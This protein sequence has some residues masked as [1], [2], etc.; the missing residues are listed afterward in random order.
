MKKLIKK[1]IIFFTI[2]ILIIIGSLVVL[3]TKYPIGYKSAIVKYSNEYNLDPYL[4]ASII[5]VESK[6][7][8]NAVSSKEAKGLM[9]IAPQTGQWAS[10]VLGI[11]NYN[12]KML[13]DPEIN[14]RIGTWYLNNLFTEFNQNLDLVLA[15]YNAGSGNVNKWLDNDEYCKDGV[16]LSVIPFKETRDYLVRI[17]DNYKVYSSVYKEYIMNPTEKDSLYIN[18]LHNIKRVVKELVRNI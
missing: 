3:T 13:F 9:Q 1:I 17:K 18:L 2:I 12:E 7:D 14:I 5:N 11:E 6:Y 15:A 4:V 10:E 8:K 16:E